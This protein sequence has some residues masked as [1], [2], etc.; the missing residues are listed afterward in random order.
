MDIL[1]QLVKAAE[2]C[3]GTKKAPVGSPKQKSFCDRMCGHKKK[4]TKSKTKK[5]PDSCI[6]KALRRWKC[7]CEA[8]ERR[9][10]VVVAEGILDGF[11]GTERG[12]S[13][14]DN[15]DCEMLSV[16]AAVLRAMYLIHH[17]NH[18]ETAG[19]EHHLLLQRLYEGVQE[20]ADDAAER[21]V[22]L[23]GELVNQELVGD[24]ASQF[25]V[26]EHKGNPAKHL[27]S[28][29]AAEQLFQTVASK[30]YDALK[31]KDALTLGLDDLIMSQASDSESHIYLLQQALKELGHEQ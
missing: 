8:S 9:A 25:I 22:G 7:R 4:N 6:N 12:E 5:D 10:L 28:S 14:L 11:I 3:E 20:M 27:Q 1:E 21:V 26:E 17:Q 30:V 16:Y 13:K 2:K 24:I 31:E 23:C 29:L 19:Y 18:L 15:D